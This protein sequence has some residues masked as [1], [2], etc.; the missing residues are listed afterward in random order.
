MPAPDALNTLRRHDPAASLA[1]AEPEARERLRRA[2]VAEPVRPEPEKR[3]RRRGLLVVVAAALALVVTAAAWSVYSVAL[4]SPETV[5]QD[6][7]EVTRTIPLPPG[8]AWEE[9]DLD[10]NG[11]Y[12]QQAGLMNALYQ[13][14]CAWLRYWD[15][16]DAAQKAEALAG[17]RRVRALMPLHP[18]GA[19]EDVGGFDQSSLDFYDRLI[20]EAEQG[21]GRL[22]RQDL[23]ANC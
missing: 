8:A 7:A 20:A 2:I 3:P 17:F 18:E 15:E 6:F 22:V 5:R 13:A 10:E 14:A 16:G 1:P 9:P 19:L 4:D 11:W 12:S 23:R 21:N